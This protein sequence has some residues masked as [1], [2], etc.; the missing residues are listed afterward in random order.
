MLAPAPHELIREQLA[1]FA[2]RAL[3]SQLQVTDPRLDLTQASEQ[4]RHGIRRCV[5]PEGRSQGGEQRADPEEHGGRISY[6]S[7]HVSSPRCSLEFS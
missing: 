5:L 2:H 4:L 7:G 1:V 3:V 6:R